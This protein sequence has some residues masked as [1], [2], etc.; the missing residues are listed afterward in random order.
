MEK[1]E[2]ALK[3]SFNN[4]LELEKKYEFFININI[5]DLQKIKNLKSIQLDLNQLKNDV[6]QLNNS[7]LLNIIEKDVVRTNQNNL[8]Y[9]FI[10][11]LFIGFSIG[12]I[13]VLFRHSIEKE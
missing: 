4:L 11:S 6:N 1:K 13:I 8:I 2:L 3:N 12:L 10:F 5:N 9:V 7:S